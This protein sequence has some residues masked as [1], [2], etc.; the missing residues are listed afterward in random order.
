MEAQEI[1]NK[2]YAGVI[3]Q[4]TQSYGDLGCKYYKTNEIRC[5]VGHCLSEEAAKDFD[6]LVN[7]DEADTSIGFITTQHASEY[8]EQWMVDNRNLLIEIQYAHD[9][10][11][12]QDGENFV[13]DFKEKM[14][15]VANKFK[16]HMPEDN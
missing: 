13:E 1:F 16:L 12:F 14:Q 2:A 3:K 9:N 8:V 7:T 10:T 5:G 4:Q 6:M 11:A 15:R